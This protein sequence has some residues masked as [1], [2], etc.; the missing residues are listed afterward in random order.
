MTVSTTAMR[1]TYACN[2]VTTEFAFPYLVYDSSHVVVIL[3][4]E[5]TNAEETLV[6]TTDYTVSGVGSDSGVT[7]TTTSTYSS[8]Y[9]LVIRREV[10]LTQTTDLVEG[11]GLPAEN[12][13]TRYD[14]ITMMIQQLN[15]ELG[16]TL[17]L[18]LDDPTSFDGVLP[19]LGTA[20]GGEYLA[21]KS[22]KAGFEF[23][24]GPGYTGDDIVYSNGVGALRTITP[25]VS[26][27]PYWL[28][29]HSTAGDGGHGLFRAV[30]GAAAGT[31]TDDGG[32][33]IVPSGGDGSAAFIRVGQTVLRPEMFG[34]TDDTAFQAALDALPANGGKIILTPGTTYSFSTG[35]SSTKPSIVIE[36]QGGSGWNAGGAVR[37]ETSGAITAFTFGDVSG[38]EQRGVVLKGFSINDTTGTAVGAV[39]IKNQWN[40]QFGD[41]LSINDFE[42]GFAFH[43]DATSGSIA[44]TTLDKVLGR[45]NKYGVKVTGSV[46]NVAATRINSNVYFALSSAIAG[47]VGV[48]I[49]DGW[50]VG[51]V[52]SYETGVKLVGD[53]CHVSGRLEGNDLHCHIAGTTARR[54]IISGA[55]FIAG[56]STASVQIDAGANIFDNVVAFNT[57][58]SPTVGIVDNSTANNFIFEP[59]QN[60]IDLT[61][62]TA[63]TVLH[64]IENQRNVA[65]GDNAEYIAAAA[66]GSV[67]AF[68]RAA[69]AT[70]G[71]RAQFGSST[72]TQVDFLVNDVE[73]ASLYRDISIGSNTTALLIRVDRSGTKTLSQ[74]SIG[75]ADSGGAGYKVLRVEN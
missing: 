31:Y 12:L 41:G 19:F 69:T 34:G 63:G 11:D 43:L 64:R 39:H 36:G 35:V 28:M 14:L 25:T 6:E 40:T 71:N 24:T 68:L 8:D 33:T 29:Y 20:D 22:N 55:R 5:A 70:S 67:E 57:Y 61:R 7:V 59:Q 27:Q 37:V 49:Q 62:S 13:E 60:D 3:V 45:Q 47:S 48:E 16:L 26:G 30:T 32:V 10:P 44:N 73:A 58:A 74:V 2:G 17:R 54:N 46:G 65:D 38:V 15:D 23:T 21:L 42:A 52:D 72:N 51:G 75:A 56:G 1:Q 4:T 50:V 66:N 9:Q 18:D 53:G